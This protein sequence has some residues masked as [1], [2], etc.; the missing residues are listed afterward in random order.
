MH[1]KDVLGEINSNRY[2]RHGLPFSEQVDEKFDRSIVALSCRK[3]Q[4]PGRT[5]CSGRGS[6][7]HSDGWFSIITSVDQALRQWWVE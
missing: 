3:P 6:P 5:A 7:F 4:P 1:G 2:D